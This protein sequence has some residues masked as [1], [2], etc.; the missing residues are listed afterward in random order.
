MATSNLFKRLLTI[1]GAQISSSMLHQLQMVVNYMKLGRWM[2][3]NDF[4]VEQRVRNRSSV[5]AV[6]AEQ[7]RNKQVLYLEFGVFKG[8]S[9]RYW[10]GAL[11][12][13]SSTL[14]G[15][16]S[17]EGLPDDFDVDGPY[18]KGSFDQNGEIP[19]I[20]DSRVKF[21]KGW[22]NEVLPSYQVPK[23]EVLVIVLDADL[24]SSTQCVLHHLCDVITPGTYIY[25]DDM[26][27][28]DHEPKAFREFIKQ[29]GL[30]FRPIAADYSL[31]YMFFECVT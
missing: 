17:F 18:T 29:S 11:T 28:P 9:M 15:F 22:F 23:H 2:V 26:S 5:F 27:R 6:V 24:Y 1:A 10:S 21:I 30:R 16:D 3:A 20:N 14:V 31:N 4:A 8:A 7:V 13:P 25:F 19:V 12:N